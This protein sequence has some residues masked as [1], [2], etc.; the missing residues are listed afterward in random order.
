MSQTAVSLPTQVYVVG[1]QEIN[2]RFYSTRLKGK[3]EEGVIS[4][5]NAFLVATGLPLEPEWQQLGQILQDYYQLLQCQS[6]I[7]TISFTHIPQEW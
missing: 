4:K 3:Q 2:M 7:G 5:I 6:Y 1:K